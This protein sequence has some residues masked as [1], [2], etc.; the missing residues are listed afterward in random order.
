MTNKLQN[1]N[2]MLKKDDQIL[3]DQ[4]TRR[5]FDRSHPPLVA[6]SDYPVMPKKLD[7]HGFTIQR[8][9][10][11]TNEFLENH[12]ALRSKFITIVCGKGGKIAE[13]LPHWCNSKSYISSCSPIMDSRGEFGAYLITFKSKRK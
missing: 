11:A 3:W 8:A 1:I 7:L 2:S 6:R 9:F 5:L 4:Y 12:L 13:E 10:K